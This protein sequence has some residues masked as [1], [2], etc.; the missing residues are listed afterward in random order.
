MKKLLLSFTFLFVF[1]VFAASNQEKADTILEEYHRLRSY[2]SE[3]EPDRMIGNF[4]KVKEFKNHIIV[5]SL[6]DDTKY[7]EMIRI[8]K[9]KGAKGF[10]ITFHRSQTIIDDRLVVRRFI[11]P[12][13]FGWRN[14]TVD[15]ETEE[16]ISAQGM[17]DPQLTE[18]D[19]KILKK[20]DIT[21]FND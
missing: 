13:P 7:H 18:G 8:Y 19:L 16:Y 6:D 12:E 9:N 11:G 21:L 20:W 17:R 5:W 1:Q 4:H 2:V 3:L 14:D 15:L 10:A